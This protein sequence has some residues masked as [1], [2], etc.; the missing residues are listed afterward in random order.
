MVKVTLNA[1]LEESKQSFGESESE[2]KEDIQNLIEKGEK[3]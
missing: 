1:S 2:L 3:L